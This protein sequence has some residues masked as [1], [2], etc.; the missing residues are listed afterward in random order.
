MTAAIVISNT[1]L[2]GQR[3][4][5]ILLIDSGRM[6]KTSEKDGCVDP[7]G[8]VWMRWFVAASDV[9][10]QMLNTRGE[11]LSHSLVPATC[12]ASILNSLPT[13][14]SSELTI[15]KG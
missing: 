8:K 13:L 5:V 11:L 4:P 15:S 3:R 12:S 9:D 14:N 2:A 1:V 6:R 7:A 10:S